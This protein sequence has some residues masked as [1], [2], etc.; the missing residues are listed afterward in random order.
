MPQ[1]IV[2]RITD[3][4]PFFMIFR[5]VAAF[6]VIVLIA[7]FVGVGIGIFATKTSQQNIETISW[8]DQDQEVIEMAFL[9]EN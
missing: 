6:A 4:Q 5:P 9:N 2:A 8:N 1:R 7:L 3:R